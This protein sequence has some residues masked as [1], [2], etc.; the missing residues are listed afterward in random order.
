M[1]GS[2]E[3]TASVKPLEEPTHTLKSIP[4]AK[5]ETAG[6][7]AAIF[8]VAILLSALDVQN[9]FGQSTGRSVG[10]TLND[11]TL[12]VRPGGTLDIKPVFFSTN[13]KIDFD[14]LARAK[15]GG[16]IL[17]GSEDYF[18]NVFDPMLKYGYV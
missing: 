6:P 8:A 5:R 2:V 12:P 9:A 14:A 13:R 17:I 16:G 10:P 1:A 7:A 18:L 11:S 4:R 15:A 3:V